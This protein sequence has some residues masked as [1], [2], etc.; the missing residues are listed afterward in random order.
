MN[1]SSLSTARNRN[2]KLADSRNAIFFIEENHPIRV[3]LRKSL[4]M[5]ALRQN[6]LALAMQKIAE[7]IDTIS[8]IMES[9]KWQHEI[10]ENEDCLTAYE[11][12]Q[13]ELKVLRKKY[14]EYSEQLTLSMTRYIYVMAVL[15][16]DKT[17]F[18]AEDLFQSGLLGIFENLSEYNYELGDVAKL[19]GLRIKNSMKSELR[20]MY[21]AVRMPTFGK[22]QT[23][24]IEIRDESGAVMY[25]VDDKIMENF[26]LV[27]EDRLN[28]MEKAELRSLIANA[29]WELPK[30][31]RKVVYYHVLKGLPMVELSQKWEC[32]RSNVTQM[33]DKAL[34]RLREKLDMN[35]IYKDKEE[36]MVESIIQ[37]LNNA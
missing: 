15:T 17:G 1:N 28:E 27:K 9:L 2:S 4:V 7:K 36:K 10:S 14:S 34:A 22:V 26:S 37:A 6:R 33:K 13:A 19:M 32:S 5:S 8:G 20:K 21:G 25:S 23:E 30:K 35:Y 11:S 24:P 18:P 29:V 16:S 3:M 31:W 12:K